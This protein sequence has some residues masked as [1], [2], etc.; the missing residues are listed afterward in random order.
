VK[1]LEIKIA[2]AVGAAVDNIEDRTGNFIKIIF[3][4]IFLLEVL[5]DRQLVVSGAEL[6]AGLRDS[7]KGVGAVLTFIRRTIRVN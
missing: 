5:V 6:K 2:G 1:L 4:E 7:Q 3:R